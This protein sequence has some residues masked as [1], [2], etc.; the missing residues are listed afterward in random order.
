MQKRIFMGFCINWI[1]IIPLHYLKSRSEFGLEFVEIFV[2]QKRLPDSLS[3]GV[4]KTAY[5][6]WQLS[7]L[8]RR[9][10]I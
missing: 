9:V 10:K 1:L 3:Q 7:M 4:D 6:G 2:I 8:Y 5:T